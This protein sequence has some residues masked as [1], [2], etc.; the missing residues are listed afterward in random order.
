MKRGNWQG[1]RI[2]VVIIVQEGGRGY[3]T[4]SGEKEVN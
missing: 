4:T 2:Y 3:F 1:P